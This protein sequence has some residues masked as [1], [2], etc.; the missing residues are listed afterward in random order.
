MSTRRPA[1]TGAS[2]RG[3]GM[4][5]ETKYL[6]QMNL[7]GLHDKVYV[8]RPSDYNDTEWCDRSGNICVNVK[9]P[10]NNKDIK[11]LLFNSKRIAD[12]VFKGINVY[13]KHLQD[14]LE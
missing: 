1:P 7:S 11:Q 9:R 4:K 5:K 14:F 6:I 8:V 2:V 10:L 12:D 13:R 3:I